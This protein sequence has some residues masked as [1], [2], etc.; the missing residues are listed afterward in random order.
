M[1]IKATAVSRGATWR[2]FFP[3]NLQEASYFPVKPP[4]GGLFSHQTSTRRAILPPKST[5]RA[6][7]PPNSPRLGRVWDGQFGRFWHA[8]RPT[9]PHLKKVS[10]R[11]DKLFF[12]SQRTKLDCLS[13]TIFTLF[14]RIRNGRTDLIQRHFHSHHVLCCLFITLFTVD[15]SETRIS[16]YDQAF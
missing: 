15:A 11:D 1:R 13:D 8:P 4:R 9:L 6:I 5:R 3:P 10:L 2:A 12:L 7:F 16:K 14:A